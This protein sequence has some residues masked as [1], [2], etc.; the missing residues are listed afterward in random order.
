MEDYRDRHPVP[1]AKSGLTDPKVCFLIRARKITPDQMAHQNPYSKYINKDLDLLLAC[2][3]FIC[4]LEKLSDAFSFDKEDVSLLYHFPALKRQ[5]NPNWLAYLFHIDALPS[6]S[7][8]KDVVNKFDDPRVVHVPLPPHPVRKC[9]AF[10]AARSSCRFACCCQ[11]APGDLMTHIF[12]IFVVGSCS[13]IRW[14]LGIQRWMRCCSR[15]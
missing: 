2:K 1:A 3:F 7:E 13:T 4:A 5:T 9:N 6:D 8:L 10:V 12:H 14:T 15:S 11:L